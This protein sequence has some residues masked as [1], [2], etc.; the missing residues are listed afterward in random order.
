MWDFLLVTWCNQEMNHHNR[1]CLLLPFLESHGAVGW[2]ANIEILLWFCGLSNC[3]LLRPVYTLSSS[4]KT[5]DQVILRT[6]VHE[7]TV[8][9]CI[10]QEAPEILS[11]DKWLQTSWNGSENSY[12][13]SLSLPSLSW[14]KRF[15]PSAVLSG[16]RKNLRKTLNAQE[17]LIMIV[18]S[19]GF[20]LISNTINFRM[21]IGSLRK[22]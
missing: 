14:E 8:N 15:I 7:S 18:S 21:N 9:H 2:D 17:Q 22:L 20:F 12:T 16:N 10:S 5:S 6:R 3:N 19:H 4:S 11:L 13:H 1:L